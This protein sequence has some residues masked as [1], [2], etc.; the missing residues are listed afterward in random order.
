M[1]SEESHALINHHLIYSNS[2]LSPGTSVRVVKLTQVA[3]QNCEPHVE[4]SVNREG[5]DEDRSRFI[6]TRPILIKTNV[7]S[8]FIPVTCCISRGGPN[9]FSPY[10]AFNI[11]SRLPTSAEQNGTMSFEK[12]SQEAEQSALKLAQNCRYLFESFIKAKNAWRKKATALSNTTMAN[13]AFEEEV[14]LLKQIAADVASRAE[15][16]ERD[17]LRPT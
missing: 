10:A 9:W 7:P 14:L 1:S 8:M 15:Q 12:I 2:S 17:G 11:S 13:E 3:K 6:I 16:L 4:L 5:P